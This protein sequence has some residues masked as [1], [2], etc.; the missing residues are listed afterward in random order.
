MPLFTLDLVG[1]DGVC[2][3]ENAFLR[4][5]SDAKNVAC[6]IACELRPKLPV[7]GY[8]IVVENDRGDVVEKIPI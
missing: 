8:Y 5:E 7:D 1:P 3:L 4:N 2:N 6:E